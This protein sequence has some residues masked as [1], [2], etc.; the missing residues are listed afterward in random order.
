VL[1]SPTSDLPPPVIQFHG[2][3]YT[4]RSLIRRRRV[5]AVDDFTLSIAPGEVL[6]LAGPNGA[7][8]TTLI[9]LM[10]GFLHPTD[11]DVQVDGL[12]PRRFV[13]RHGVGYLSELVNIPPRWTLERALERFAL[14]AGVPDSELRG[15]V[16]AVIDRLGIGE[17]RKKAVRQLSKG[18]LQRL[19]LAQAMLRDERV[20]ILDEPTHGLDPVWTQRFRDIAGELRRPDRIIFIASHN[21]DELQRVA[22]RVAIIDR[23]RL[24]RVVATR[25]AAAVI[26]GAAPT[27]YLI[28]LAYGS[29]LVTSVFPGARERARGEFELPATELSALNSGIAELV[30]R[31]ALVSMLTPVHTALEQHFR[32]AVGEQ[33]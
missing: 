27:P 9:A 14:L 13:E 20:L 15:R 10:L 2:V 23:G 4:Y 32:E 18:N 25:T 29:E 12:S 6:G 24:Q 30:A 5:R 26:D 22:D 8:K 17:H 33:T 21:L 19:G 7:G 11:G 3:G 1:S 28:T 16:D 31:G